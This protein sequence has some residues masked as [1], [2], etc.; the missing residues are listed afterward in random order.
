LIFMVPAM[1]VWIWGD[2]C[3]TVPPYA[4]LERQLVTRCIDDCKH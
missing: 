1:L 4:E 3:H 2:D